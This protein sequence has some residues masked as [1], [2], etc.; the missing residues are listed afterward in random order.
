MKSVGLD[1]PIEN[2]TGLGNSS[3]FAKSQWVVE[4]AAEGYNDFYF[5]D[6]AYKNVKAVQDALS[7]ID[8][9]S[10]VQQAHVKFSKS[11]DLSKTLNDIIEAKTDIPS[12][13]TF[14]QLAKGI[15]KRKGKRKHFLSS[16]PPCEGLSL[17]TPP[18]PLWGGPPHPLAPNP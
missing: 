4:K 6:D 7:V 10:K 15:G 9:K 2:I 12:E 8:V 16:W 14:D 17:P 11:V 3:P 13:Q 5:A 18:Q 1:I